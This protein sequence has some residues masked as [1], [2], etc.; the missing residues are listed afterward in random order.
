M[1]REPV[2]RYTRDAAGLGEEVVAQ[3]GLY[4]PPPDEALE[5]DERGDADEAACHAW[6]YAAADDEVCGGEYKGE[7][8]HTAPD[9]MPPFHCVDEFEFRER[10]VGVE[11]PEL[12]GVAV[13]GEGVFPVGGV[14][15]REGASD[16]FPFGYGEAGFGEAGEAAEDNDAEDEAGGTEEP[17]TD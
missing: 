8:N 15:G 16:G 6:G 13:E 2:L 11:V 14:E 4:H 9:A 5:A 3:A 1:C 7:A 10:H 12:G 17:E